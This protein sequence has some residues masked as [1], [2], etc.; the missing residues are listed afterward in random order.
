MGTS[1]DIREIRKGIASRPAL[2]TLVIWNILLFIICKFRPDL[3]ALLSLHIPAEAISP[4]ADFGV[5]LTRL[6]TYT[7]IHNSAGHLTANMIWLLP[8][9]YVL[10]PRLGIAKFLLLYFA[11]GFAGGLLFIAVAKFGAFASSES[12]LTL[13][14]ASASVIGIILCAWILIPNNPI[15]NIENTT[16]KNLSKIKIW[17]FTAALITFIITPVIYPDILSLSAHIGG[18]L[19]GAIYA[20]LTGKN[21]KGIK[22]RS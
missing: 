12:I 2:A 5:T 14:G 6:F 4:A 10:Y 8:F 22:L 11:A 17:A 18:A 13:C 19:F 1:I 16:V 7:F 21:L 9:G 15:L 20:L 3:I